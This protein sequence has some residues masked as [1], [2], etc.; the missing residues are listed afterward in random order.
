MCR[1]VPGVIT[2][3]VLQYYDYLYD[4]GKHFE[5][6]GKGG[7]PKVFDS[8]PDQLHM[9][10]TL[11]LKLEL[12]TL[13]PL[14]KAMDMGKSENKRAILF[15]FDRLVPSVGIPSE[16][17]AEKHRFA[18]KMHFL[19]RGVVCML[20]PSA[21]Q[22]ESESDQ[23]YRHVVAA[24]VHAKEKRERL[25]NLSSGLS[26]R[27]IKKAALKNAKK[28]V[29]AKTLHEAAKTDRTASSPLSGAI[30][31]GQFISGGFFGQAALMKPPA[32]RKY[33]ASY[34]CKTYW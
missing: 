19:M 24:S 29:P 30:E 18:D 31:V 25:K 13:C 10:L 14:F 16:V 34:K 21:K 33:C 32:H 9:Q 26:P 27:A 12:V 2:N 3:Q 11:S 22:D 5:E 7:L 28:V 8:L 15:I 17:V 6:V 4:S 20:M 1:Q 23:T